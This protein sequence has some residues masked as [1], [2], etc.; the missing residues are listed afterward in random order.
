[1]EARVRLQHGRMEP[2]ASSRCPNTRKVCFNGQ[3]AGSDGTCCDPPA[4]MQLLDDC[5]ILI[6]QRDSRCHS[7]SSMIVMAP[8]KLSEA[9]KTL[10]TQVHIHKEASCVWN[11][12]CFQNEWRVAMMSSMGMRPSIPAVLLPVKPPMDLLPNSSSAEPE[13]KTIR[14]HI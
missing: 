2:V 8:D 5:L 1:M 13:I 9:L 10:S 6:P 11:P 12:H 7:K 14:G 4:T 3:R